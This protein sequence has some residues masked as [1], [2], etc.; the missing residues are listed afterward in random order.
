[1][2]RNV[3]HR[4]AG[5]GEQSQMGKAARQSKAEES[6]LSALVDAAESVM[7]P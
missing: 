1:M 3:S 2:H 4:I 7:R 5:L 6:F